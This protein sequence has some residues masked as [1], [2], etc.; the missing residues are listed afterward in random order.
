M[1][2]R[3]TGSADPTPGRE[4]G[5]TADQVEELAGLIGARRP[6]RKDSLLH[7][8]KGS[9][10]LRD[11]GAAWVQ[12]QPSANKKTGAAF[13]GVVRDSTTSSRF[14]RL[15]VTGGG[16]TNPCTFFGMV[17]PSS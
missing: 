8:R 2:E 3:P 6:Y 11:R 1:S 10:R 4:V 16:G 7:R 12:A 14:A 5:L 15:T 9:V 13:D 17:I